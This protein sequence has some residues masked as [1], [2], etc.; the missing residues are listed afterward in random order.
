MTPQA[1][2]ELKRCL[3][4]SVGSLFL[5]PLALSLIASIASPHDYSFRRDYLDICEE[6]FSTDPYAVYGWLIILAPAVIY[7]F[8]LACIYYC[9][10]PD[11]IRSVFEFPRW[12]R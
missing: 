3:W 10:H 12:R 6:L 8:V 1:S 4:I 7:E 11:Q 9:R 2:K 5:T